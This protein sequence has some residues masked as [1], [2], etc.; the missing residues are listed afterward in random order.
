MKTNECIKELFNI[1]KELNVLNRRLRKFKLYFI[2]NYFSVENKDTYKTISKFEIL[3]QG[4]YRKLLFN[5]EELENK[6]FVL[7]K[8]I[9]IEKQN[10]FNNAV[11]D[12]DKII[13]D[14]KDNKDFLQY[15]GI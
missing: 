9:D 5:I 11:I 4:K 1:G 7:L 10:I 8:L 6:K 3:F 12:Y 15:F 2:E 13:K 14:T